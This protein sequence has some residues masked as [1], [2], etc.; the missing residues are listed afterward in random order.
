MSTPVATPYEQLGGEPVLRALVD[1]FYDRIAE[2]FPLLGDMLPRDTTV[3]RRKL[4][5]FLSGWLGGPPLY[6]ERYGHPRLRMRHFPFTIDTEAA[7]QWIEAMYLTL[8]ELDLDG[9]LDT[10]L[11]ARFLQTA[12]HMRNSPDS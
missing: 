7:R 11:R 3:T 8:D 9:D 5:E 1:G 10:F 6:M 2:S 4:F 12:A